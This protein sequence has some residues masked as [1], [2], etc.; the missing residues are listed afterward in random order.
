MCIKKKTKNKKKQ[1]NKQTNKQISKIYICIFHY[2]TVQYYKTFIFAD[3]PGL[4]SLFNDTFNYLF[5]KVYPTNS[6]FI[7]KDDES[8]LKRK[9]LMAH[10]EIQYDFPAG[11]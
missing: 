8:Y 10:Y 6:F 4:L 3:Y 1:T 2:F 9:H 7:A 5:A 11:T